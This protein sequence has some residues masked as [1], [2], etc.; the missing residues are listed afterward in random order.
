MRPLSAVF[1]IILTVALMLHLAPASEALHDLFQ[2][3]DANRDGRIDR[4]E[5]SRNMVEFVFNKID[6]N[7]SGAIARNEWDILQDIEDREKHDQLYSSMDSDKNSLISMSEFAHYAQIHSNMYESFTTLDVDQNNL[8]SPE[9]IPVRP[10]FMMVT[11]Q[12]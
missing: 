4:E 3:M 10:P 6:D 12:F 8:L 11:L 2:T 7:N 1:P 9:E 5:F